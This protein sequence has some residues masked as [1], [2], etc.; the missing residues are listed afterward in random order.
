[1]A[2]KKREDIAVLI[3]AGAAPKD[4]IANLG[5]TRS[6]IL[7]VRKRLES[8]K[9]LHPSPKKPRSPLKRTPRAVAAVQRLSLIHI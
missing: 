7:R 8:G 5:T 6:T 2:E 3:R 1:M 9:G 4:I